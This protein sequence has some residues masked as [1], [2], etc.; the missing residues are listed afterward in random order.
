MK[1]VAYFIR[2]NVYLA[3]KPF[4]LTKGTLVNRKKNMQIGLDRYQFPANFPAPRYLYP[5]MW[6]Y[7]TCYSHFNARISFVRQL[8]YREPVKGANILNHLAL[9]IPSDAILGGLPVLL[10]LKIY[11]RFGFLSII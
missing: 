1:M 3:N 7:V 9:G 10:L 8:I 4:T 6:P 11:L 2:S 5:G